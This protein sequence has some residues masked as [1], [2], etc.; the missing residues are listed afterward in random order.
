[1]SRFRILRLITW[2]P[3]G[4]IERKIVAVL[5][6]LDRDLFEPH[7]CCLRERGPL[8]DEL[9]RLGVPVH[10]VKFRSRWDPVALG[11]LL[12]MVRSLGV[13]LIHAH[14]YRANVPATMLGLLEPRLKVVGQYHNV[15]TWESAGQLRMDRW[16]ARRRAANVCVSEAVRRDVITRLSLDPDRVRTIHNG[17]DLDE[18]RPVASHASQLAL[19]QQL[20]L[21]LGGRIVVTVARL[22]AQKNQAVLL[23]IAPEILR[24]VPSAHFLFVGG[25]P[26][27]ESLRTLAAQLGVAESVT[28]LGSRD[29]VPD[30]LRASDVAVLPSLKEGFSNTILESLASG[31]PVVASDVGGNREVVDRGVNGY[32]V[33]VDRDAS[34]RVTAVRAGQLA[35]YL[36]RLLADDTLRASMASA[37]RRSAGQ[38]DIGMMVGRVEGLYRDVLEG[39]A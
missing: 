26:M 39:G 6:R 27:E 17:V 14:M 7:V 16:L 38:F 31:L 36:K 24:A 11:R 15:D 32:I 34:G 4:G 12:R 29:D 20:G 10:V 3:T 2:L 37:A 18:F 22:V 1:M 28:F 5:P 23:R 21:P 8:A 13:D 33:D 35:R 30:I 19:R 25:G 9:E